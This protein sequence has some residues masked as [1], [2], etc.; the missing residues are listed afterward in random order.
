[1]AGVSEQLENFYHFA[2]GRLR[3][4]ECGTA[5]LDDLY[6]EWR[7]NNPD[8]EVLEADTLAVRA[9]LRDMEAGEAG[10]PITEFIAEFRPKNGLNW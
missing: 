7:A 1:M 3:S 9:S 10:R 5:S 2:W 6:A 4:G 8:H